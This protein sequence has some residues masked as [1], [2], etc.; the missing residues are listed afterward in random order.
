VITS[1]RDVKKIAFVRQFDLEVPVSTVVAKAKAARMPLTPTQVHRI[2][3]ELRRKGAE[4]KANGHATPPRPAPTRPAIDNSN[5]R[6]VEL[7]KLILRMG[8][9]TA[10]AVMQE[11]LDAAGN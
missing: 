11:L 9:D 6:V 7:R 2:R 10:S 1:E 3:W 8:V 4:A 5:P